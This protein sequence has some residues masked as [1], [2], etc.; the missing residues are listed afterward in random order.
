[1]NPAIPRFFKRALIL[2]VVAL[3]ASYSCDYLYLRIRMVPKFGGDGLGTATI[4]YAMTAK[5]GKVEIFYERPVEEVC[6]RSLFPHLGHEPC[7]Y[8]YRS[9]TRLI[10]QAGVKDT[11]LPAP[12]GTFKCFNAIDQRIAQAYFSGRPST[13]TT[14]TGPY[15][16]STS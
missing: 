1:M 15:F 3:A 16:A 14:V 4:Y 2:C 12:S 6:V 13:S 7:W 5:N 9:P 11:P 10:A 8:L